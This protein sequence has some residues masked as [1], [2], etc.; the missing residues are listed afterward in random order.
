[1]LFA[2]K[3]LPVTF[4]VI[5]PYHTFHVV[6][7]VTGRFLEKS[8]LLFGLNCPQLLVHFIGVFKKS[9]LILVLIGYQL[10]V[11]DMPYI[12]LLY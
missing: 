5:V 8:Q 10:G 4:Y 3:C 2:L 6:V 12:R 7:M 11:C 9:L 1:M